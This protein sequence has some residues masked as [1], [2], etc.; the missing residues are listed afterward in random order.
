MIIKHGNLFDSQVDEL[1][2]C[3]ITSS[4]TGYSKIMSCTKT[5]L[6]LNLLLIYVL[7]QMLAIIRLGDVTCVIGIFDESHFVN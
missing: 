6:R 7:G 2:Y 5:P 4:E 1:D 3:D